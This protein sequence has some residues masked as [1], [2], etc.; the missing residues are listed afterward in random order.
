MTRERKELAVGG[1]MVELVEDFHARHP[2]KNPYDAGKYELVVD[3][4]TK[5]WS[6]FNRRKPTDR[7]IKRPVTRVAREPYGNGHAR[8]RV[9]PVVVTLRP[10]DV[11]ET[12]L[13]GT[14]RS[15][16]ITWAKLHEYLVRRYA[17]QAMSAK[18]AERA[19]RKQTRKARKR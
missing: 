7:T 4:K 15:Y 8:D 5:L 9:R 17:L 13:K 6:L 18:R 12:R 2:G 14:R 11:I 19:A 1:S 16:S 10:G 3:E